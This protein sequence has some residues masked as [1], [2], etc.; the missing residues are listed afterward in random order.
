MGEKK[1]PNNP[2]SG[3]LEDQIKIQRWLTLKITFGHSLK[4]KTLNSLKAE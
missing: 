4:V 2:E 1:T 3:N